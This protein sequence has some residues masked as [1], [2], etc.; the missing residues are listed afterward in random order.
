MDR[1]Q[2][3]LAMKK[4][5]STIL[6][7]GAKLILF[8][9]RARGVTNEVSDWDI[10]VL[11]NKSKRTLQDIDDYG[12]PFRELG[13]DLNVEINPIISTFSEMDSKQHYINLY[14]NIS[15]EGIVLWE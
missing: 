1:K 2:I 10:L 9:S 7:Q 14:N 11:L 5:A 6:P 4:L 15:K 13:W 12:Y 3:I 8:G